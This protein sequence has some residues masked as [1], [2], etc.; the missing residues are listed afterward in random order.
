MPAC[1]YASAKKRTHTH[2]LI[3]THTQRYTHKKPST[4][5]TQQSHPT[6]HKIILLYTGMLVHSLSHKHPT[7]SHPTLI[8]HTQ[9]HS[10]LSLSCTCAHK[11]TYPHTQTYTETHPNMHT[12]S[13][14]RT[15]TD[16]PSPNAVNCK[17]N[18][19]TSSHFDGASWGLF[20]RD[21][22]R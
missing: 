13:S 1:L 2:I 15:Q 20:L 6:R 7:R 19:L 3:H 22:R 11:H 12:H 5:H 16:T 9:K 21:F 10:P 8:F 4:L 18:V 17:R 14:S